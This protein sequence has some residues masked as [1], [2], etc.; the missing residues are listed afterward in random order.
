MKICP[1][2]C[3]LVYVFLLAFTTMVRAEEVTECDRLASYPYDQKAISDP[4]PDHELN[5]PLAIKA[6]ESALSN[7]PENARHNFNLGRALVLDQQSDRG[8]VFIRKA[9]E[10]EYAAA[11]LFV[12]VISG[13]SQQPQDI[14]DSIYWYQLAVNQG[15]AKAAENLGAII[16][17][18]QGG[19]VGEYREF[20][21]MGEEMLLKADRMGAYKAKAILAYFYLIDVRYE[22]SEKRQSASRILKEE[23]L[24]GKNFAKAIYALGVVKGLL[25]PDEYKM[26][27][28]VQ[29]ISLEVEDQNQLIASHLYLAVSGSDASKAD[30]Y[31]MAQVVCKWPKIDVVDPD[32]RSSW[33]SS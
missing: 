6:C 7:D 20:A 21:Q 15:S 28:L 10:S 22:K 5:A 16:F 14:K 3:P 30:N 19:G 1:R 8:L 24:R 27:E 18:L 17:G 31:E 12:A 32:F 2:F 25:E 23:I 26:N 11:T 13:L 29:A 4:I 33:C 9:V